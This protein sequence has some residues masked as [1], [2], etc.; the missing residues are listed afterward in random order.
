MKKIITMILMLTLLTIMG[1]MSFANVKE[2]ENE[3]K[4]ISLYYLNKENGEPL[5]VKIDFKS[6]KKDIIEYALKELLNQNN[7]PNNGH[8]EI[9]IDTK[10]N[11]IILEDGILTI[12]LNHNFEK[13]VTSNINMNFILMSFL[14]TAF[15]FDEVD[16]VRF[17]FDKKVVRYIGE[18]VFYDTFKRVKESNPTLSTTPKS[19][20]APDP[21]VVIDPGHGGYDPGAVYGT[22]YEKDINLGIALELKNHLENKG[23]IVYMTRTNDTHVELEERVD[24][25]NDLNADF[26]VSVHINAS[27]LTS[28]HGTT[29]T[30][31]NNHDVTASVSLAN[32]VHEQ[33]CDV[34]NQATIYREPNYANF[35]VTRETNMPA[36]LNET[37]FISNSG[38]RDIISSGSGQ[39]VIAYE[40]YSGIRKWWWG[41]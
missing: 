26:F 7:I 9:P 16:E 20:I 28:A 39:D 33:V 31:P 23:A 24:F 32:D 4:K 34:F 15:Q 11:D 12:D 38:D 10:I 13:K 3:N 29:V 14:E 30:Y 1:L 22:L 40:I 37:G 21:V 19:V 2:N 36:I 5:E 27:T 18:Y 17:T 6:E 41:N 35:Q 25:A 8:S